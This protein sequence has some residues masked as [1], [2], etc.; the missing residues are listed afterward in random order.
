MATIQPVK[1]SVWNQI[2]PTTVSDEK[3]SVK[4][5]KKMVALGVSNIAY[6]RFNIP[7]EVII[8]YRY[9]VN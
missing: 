5:V 8:I 3:T 6:L 1:T 9:L 7:E 4:L 2:F